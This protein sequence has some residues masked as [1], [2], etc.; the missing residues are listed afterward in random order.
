MKP[1][2]QS[3]FF[4]LSFLLV[5]ANLNAQ[6]ITI[7]PPF[8]RSDDTITV[9]FDATQGNGGLMGV[10][11][12]YAHT[13]VITNLSGP[14]EW[15]YVIGN[16]GTDD[17]RVKMTKVD[18]NLHKLSYHVRSF[19]GV[20]AGEDI[21]ELAFVFRNVNGSQEGKTET[22]GDIFTPLYDNFS[23]LI[24]IF[25]SQ[26]PGGGILPIGAEYPIEIVASD[27][28]QIELSLNDS[29][30]ATGFGLELS[31]VFT[32]DEGGDYILSFSAYN[33]SDSVFDSQS[34]LV[35]PGE[36]QTAPFPEDMV[37]GLNHLNDSSILFGLYAPGKESVFLLGDF[38]DWKPG[39]D[40]LLKFDPGQNV[41]WIELSGLEP[42]MEYAFQY[43]VDGSIRIADPYSEMVLDPAHD[44]FIPESTFPNLKPYPHGKTNGIVGVFKPR[45]DVYDWQI[46]DF[47]RPAVEDLV[48]YELLVRDFSEERNFQAVID[49]LDYLQR[50]GV[51][52]IEL[53]PVNEF[54]G[55][56]SWG[57]N[58]SF[59]MALDKFY[60]RPEDLK[61]LIDEAHARGMAVII[62]IVL[63]H[64]F[65]QSPLCQLYWDAQNFRP[66]PDNP[67]LN[68]TARH[69]F[70][71][72]YDF[73][74]ESEATQ[75]W[76]DRIMRYW[77][78]EYNIDGYR[79][80]LSKG[81]TQNFTTDVGAWSEYDADRIR[82]LKRMSDVIREIDEDF[83]MILEHFAVDE[84]ERELS[85]A[86]MLMWGNMHFNYKQAAMSFS[87]SNFSRV[88]HK[89]RGFNDPHLIGYMESHDEE[90]LMYENLEFGNSGSDGYDIRKLPTALRRMELVNTFLYTVPGPKMLWQFGEF[91]YDYS[92]F[93]CPGGGV[94]QDC[95]LDIKPTAWE[96]LEEPER[97]RLFQVTSALIHL[98]LNHDVFRTDDFEMDVG[99]RFWKRIRLFGDD[100]NVNVLGNFDVERR[101]IN[102]IFPHTGMW[103]EFFSGDSIL[104]E[105]INM[106][107]NMEPGE[108][109]IYTT[110]K[111]DKPDITTSAGFIPSLQDLELTLFPNPA[112]NEPIYLEF[113]LESAG[114]AYLRLQDA[115]GRTI[116][117]YNFSWLPAGPHNISIGDYLRMPM[118]KG[119]MYFISIL[120]EEG[121]AVRKL[122]VVK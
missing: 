70:N 82:L 81:F 12:V 88:S 121:M 63:N 56:I 51:N 1:Y 30:I 104:I 110:V 68:V 29:I 55:N 108:Y 77:I 6:I 71:V 39:M 78:E 41:W 10:D 35:L 83:Y 67:W 95:K 69:P 79:F 102:P 60:G 93:Y 107:L 50:L 62:D 58:P 122:K 5:C 94:S 49:S 117:N 9:F 61:R 109:R 18:D 119:G 33:D 38:N 75:Y 66:A 87:G 54:E 2:F 74:H 85:D 36:T 98:K 120:T 76:V 25:N 24:A 84:E 42:E 59:H 65:S 23:G 105:N 100:M 3:S 26:P 22:G 45:R 101:D 4:L 89:Q 115:S 90:R 32:F 80:D 106:P 40:Y 21:L 19:Y 112:G 43:L 86:G 16:W 52:A 27:S 111:L 46:T 17:P 64:A 53:L 47:K 37:H 91:G 99:A 113:A 28:A 48:I 96:Y 97:Q 7:D 31:T 20:P 72:G 14:G 34:I 57:Y 11:Q 44:P 15:R 114:P 8:P 116:G 118:D 13:G 92:I 103:Y 73:N